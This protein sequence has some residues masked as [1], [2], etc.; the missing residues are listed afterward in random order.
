MTFFSNFI[1]RVVE[2][3]DDRRVADLSL[4]RH[5]PSVLADWAERAGIEP[6]EFDWTDSCWLTVRVGSADVARYLDE[7]TDPATA[8]GLK[9]KLEPNCAYK[10]MAEEF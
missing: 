8:E 1:Y 4:D 5:G 7:F 2:E 6:N 3:G 10:I 9:A